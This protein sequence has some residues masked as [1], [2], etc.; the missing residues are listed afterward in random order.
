[1]GAFFRE[2]ENAAHITELSDTSPRRTQRVL[3]EASL[4][5]HSDTELLDLFKAGSHCA[6]DAM[7]ILFTRYRR[8]VLSIS[9]K[10]LR[11]RAEAED[12]VHEVFLEIGRKAHLFN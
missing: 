3:D 6:N 1:M 2:S 5:S 12:M 8:L 7:G 4:E 11:D 9:A 10:I